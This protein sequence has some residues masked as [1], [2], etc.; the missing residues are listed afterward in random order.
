MEDW[1]VSKMIKNLSVNGVIPKEKHAELFEQY[2]KDLANGISKGDSIARTVL[3]LANENLIYKFV[4][5]IVK[6]IT[7]CDPES[8]LFFNAKLGLIEAVDTFDLSLNNAF[9]TY[10]FVIINTFILRYLNKRKKDNLIIVSLSTMAK[11]KNGEPMEFDLPD[12]Y[13]L[14]EDVLNKVES[15]N[16][17]RRII[18]CFNHLTEGEQKSVILYFGLFGQE[19]VSLLDYS[20]QYNYPRQSLYYQ[21]NKALEKLRVLLSKNELNDDDKKKYRRYK[22][23]HHSLIPE[24]QDF[25]EKEFGVSVSV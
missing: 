17:N 19:K 10:A 18:N 22:K 16:N 24:V 25:Y 14:S 6:G 1:K 20:K 7:Y 5:K 23:M 8:E 2:K 4:P 12:D 3:I 21:L 11:D 9:S 15:E 13:N